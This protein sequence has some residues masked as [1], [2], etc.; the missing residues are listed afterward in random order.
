MASEQNRLSIITGMAKSGSQLSA[1]F[2]SSGKHIVSVG[3]DSRVYLWNHDSSPV[4]PSKN[5]AV[6]SVRSCEYFHSEAVSVAL[7]WSSPGTESLLRINS[8]KSLQFCSRRL[9]CPSEGR[10]SDRFSIGN[11][12]SIEGPCLGTATWPEEKLPLWELSEEEEYGNGSNSR[13]ASERIIKDSIR[14]PETWGL[15]LVTAS[16]DGKIR[17][18]HNYGLP[19]RF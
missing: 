5:K 18:L 12:F 19:G 7:P 17:T 16:F 2:S 1:S 8:S 13:R 10:D 11:C 4:P 9:E 3:D 15:V 6:K 14:V